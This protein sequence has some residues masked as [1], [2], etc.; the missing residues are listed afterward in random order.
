[1]K[2]KGDLRAIDGLGR[3]VVPMTFRKMLGIQTGDLLELNLS[4]N[5][6]IVITKVSDSCVFCGGREEL[7]EY[8][9]K[10]VCA[11]CKSELN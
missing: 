2:E 5:N 4:S 11:K 8:R 7:T 9:E 3:I 10:Y 6:E 1:M